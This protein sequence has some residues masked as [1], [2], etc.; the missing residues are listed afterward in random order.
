VRAGRV[1]VVESGPGGTLSDCGGITL[2]AASAT[3][4]MSGWTGQFQDNVTGRCATQSP[5]LTVHERR[6]LADSR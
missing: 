6:P 2:H 3:V 1:L 5:Q 4:A